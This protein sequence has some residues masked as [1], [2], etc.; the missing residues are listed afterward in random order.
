[1]YCSGAVTL[2]STLNIVGNIIGNGTALTNLNYNSI[3]NPPTIPNFN[4]P[5]T[6]TSSLF[7]SGN[8]ILQN[9]T[10]Y[11]STLTVYSPII[12]GNNN[13]IPNLH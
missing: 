8:T 6:L 11:L 7:V 13:S 3:L 4:S 9:A 2:L 12:V 1:M 5:C 10:T